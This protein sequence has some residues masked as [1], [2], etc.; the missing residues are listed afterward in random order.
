V[1]IDLHP[2]LGGQFAQEREPIADEV[3]RGSGQVT[4][5]RQR[6]TQM[7]FH[8]GVPP[9]L[10]TGAG[11]EK[12]CVAAI[13]LR[14]SATACQLQGALRSTPPQLG[15]G[16]GQSTGGGSRSCLTLI[17]FRGGLQEESAAQVSQRPQT[18]CLVGVQS[19]C[20]SRLEELESDLR[21]AGLDQGQDSVRLVLRSC[22]VAACDGHH[23]GHQTAT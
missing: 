17:E 15:L 12:Q 11:H 18:A 5:V 14:G 4:E 9:G 8:L 13:P 20:V 21:F 2:V 19:I 16:P 10:Q 22:G 3:E 6:G 7:G 1:P 23:G